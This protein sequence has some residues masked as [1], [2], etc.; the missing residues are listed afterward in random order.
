MFGCEREMLMRQ[1]LSNF[2]AEFFKAL[3]HPLRISILDE[4]RGGEMTVNEISQKFAV[5]P[6]TETFS[7]LS[8][9]ESPGRNRS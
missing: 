2:K 3:A 8:P 5:E 9:M 6:A 4:L 7:P 1:K